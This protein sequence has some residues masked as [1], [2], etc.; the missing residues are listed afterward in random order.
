MSRTRAGRKSKTIG[1]KAFQDTDADILAWWE[2]MPEGERSSILRHLIRTAIADQTVSRNQNGNGSHGN[3][4][5]FAQV[6]EDTAWIRNAL[7][8]LPTYLDQLVRQVA[9]TRPV[10][11][12]M[13]T[14]EL[15]DV[16][17]RLEQEAIERRRSKMR[18]N[19]W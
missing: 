8:D 6:C 1:L 11:Q 5:Q 9:A 18:Q 14:D 17:P 19:A 12:V 7:S 3:G 15:P 4:N 2:G 13:M 16:V 10:S